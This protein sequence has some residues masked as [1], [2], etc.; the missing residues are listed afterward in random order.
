MKTLALASTLTRVASGSVQAAD[1]PKL[2]VTKTRP[3]S[4]PEISG[5]G[6]EGES[7]RERLLRTW[8]L[9]PEA[10][11][12]LVSPEESGGAQ[13]GAGMVYLSEKDGTDIDEFR[14]GSAEE[15]D[16]AVVYA[17]RAM[18]PGDKFG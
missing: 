4:P 6:A 16:A 12:D 1:M 15:A 3:P 10:E 9:Y 17:L 14:F 5:A 13:D 11:V 7:E 8:R 18:N 2:E